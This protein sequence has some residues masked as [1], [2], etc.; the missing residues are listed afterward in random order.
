MANITSAIIPAV[1]HLAVGDYNVF[2]REAGPADAPTILLLHG[3]PTSSFMFRHLIPILAVSYHVIALDYPG[4]GFTTTPAKFPHTFDNLATV[5]EKFLEALHISK[6]A[7]YIFDYGAPV[8]LKLAVRNPKSVTAIIS[9][10]GNAYNEGLGPFWDPVKTYWASG[11]KADRAALEGVLSFNTTEGQYT[12]GTKDVAALEPESWWL[13]WTLMANRPGNDDYQLDLFYDYRNNVKQYP[14]FQEY[15]R[16]SQ[17]PL[18]AVWGEK[19]TIFVPPGAKAFK[20]DLP[21]AEIHLLDAGHFTLISNLDQM[22]G[23][24]LPFLAKHLGKGCA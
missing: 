12:G 9:Q 8:G 23:Y 4:F 15:F 11:S 17:V 1:N 2:Y 20:R 3:F 10:N 18:L 22:V 6:Y 7:L 14:E 5:T 24:I 21:K 19:D 16:K 13:D